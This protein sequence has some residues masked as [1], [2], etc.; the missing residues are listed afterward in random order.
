VQKRGLKLMKIGFIDARLGST[1]GVS[2]ETAK[3]VHVFK[4][5]GHKIYFI[6][7]E[8]ENPPENTTIIPEMGF[9]TDDN[10]WI[11]QNAFNPTDNKQLLYDKINTIADIIQ[12]KISQAIDKYDLDLIVLEN[13]ITIPMQIPLGLAIKNLLHSNPMP[14]IAHHHDFYWERSRFLKNNVQDILDIAFP[15]QEKCLSHSCI[16]SIQQKELKKRFNIDATVVPNVFDFNA[17]FNKVDDFNCDFR[18]TLGISKENILFL[19]PSRIVPRK[20]IEYS[21]ELVYMLNDKNIKFVLA[22]YSGDEGEDYLI[23]LK[24]L[25]QKRNITACFAH[26]HISSFRQSEPIK[27]YT[28]WD[29]YVHCDLVTFPSDFEGFGNHVVEAFYFKKPLFVNNYSVYEADINPTGVDVILIDGKVTD[30]AVEKTREVLKN[31]QYYHE[32]VERNFEIGRRKF[33]FETLQNLLTTMIANHPVLAA[34][35]L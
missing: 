19:Q 33:S 27:K 29:S 11:Q 30:E 15:V 1:D 3:W 12:Q 13:C 4:K 21:V 35:K 20:T 2:L 5:M 9:F 24:E 6:V 26:E 18:Q 16:N 31:K 23:E 25:I 34:S 10:N 22:G 14:A 32:M 17:D 8:Y 28:L 7:G